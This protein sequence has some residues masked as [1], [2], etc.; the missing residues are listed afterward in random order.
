MI[1]SEN[2]PGRAGKWVVA[3]CAPPLFLCFFLCL[4][5]AVVLGAA[6]SYGIVIAAFISAV[7]FAYGVVVGV[8]VHM[9]LVRLNKRRLRHYQIAGVVLG[10]LFG[11]LVAASEFPSP[12]GG[13]GSRLPALFAVLVVFLG[14]VLGAGSWTIRWKALRPDQREGA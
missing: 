2:K 11:T 13:G 7:Y 12:M 3:L 5:A 8:P 4:V 1:Q 6:G 9:A 14:A 10:A